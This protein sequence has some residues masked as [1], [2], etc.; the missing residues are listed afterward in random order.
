MNFSALGIRLALATAA[1]SAAG[2][3]PSHSVSGIVFDSVAARPLVEAIVQV[4]QL[5]STSHFTTH[6]W[7]GTTDTKGHFKVG[8]LPAGRFALGF[9]H[10]ALAALGLESPLR[11]VSF[12]GDTDV[13]VDLAIPSGA[14]VRAQNCGTSHDG[15][16]VGYVRDAT[17]GASLDSASVDLHWLEIEHTGADYRT[18]PHRVV[19]RTDDGGRYQ[20]C[21]LPEGMPVNLAV[22]HAGYRELDG[23]IGIVAGSVG[24]RD[25]HLAN[26]QA[27]R[28]SASIQGR[29]LQADSAP[30]RSGHVRVP[31]LGLETAIAD[32]KFSITGLPPGTWSLETQVIGY[33]PERVLVDALGATP[34]LATIILESK[35]QPLDAITIIGKPNVVETGKLAEIL[36]RKRGGFGTIYMPGDER[37]ARADRLTDLVKVAPGFH[38]GINRFGNEV[39][40]GRA[41]ASRMVPGR[42]LPDLIV[43]GMRVDTLMIPMK[44][45]LAVAAYPDLLGVP[46]QYRRPGTNC[47]ILVWTK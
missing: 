3:Q 33:E 36:D 9:Q 10:G 7:W 29:V 22:S 21:G 32:G 2:A 1:W 44:D 37:I 8:G 12:A 5:D 47:A 15:M 31:A 18:V 4:V 27:V 41:V 11:V 43:D 38:V 19:Q 46:V 16:L 34:V 17:T 24:Q 39:I 20:V 35:A 25:V 40:E 30:V 23:E 14:V 13:T 42:C 28:G 26:A 6:A 45:V